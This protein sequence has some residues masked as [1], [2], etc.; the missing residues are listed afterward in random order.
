MKRTFTLLTLALAVIAFSAAGANAQQAAPQD[1]TLTAD[2]IDLSC[3]VAHNLSGA[4]H[5]M[6]AQVCAD[7]GIPLALFANGQV[8]VPVSMEM[9]GTS[10]NATLREFAEQKVQVK[11]KVIDRGGIKAI[12]IEQVTKA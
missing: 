2:V 6:C 7:K 12:V 1:I 9:P 4:D 3:K 10:A 11:G 5:R 8:Y